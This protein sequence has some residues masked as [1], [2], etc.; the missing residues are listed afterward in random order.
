MGV[1]A[2]LV[3][4]GAATFCAVIILA[5][6]VGFGADSGDPPPGVTLPSLLVQ[7][8]CLAGAALLFA[9]AAGPVTVRQFGLRAPAGRWSW[10]GWAALAMLAFIVFAN[11]WLELIDQTDARDELPQE[12]GADT[13]AAAAVVT[14]AL[15]C[16]LAPLVE[17]F[18]FRGFIFPAMRNRLGLWGGAAVTGLLFG[19]AHVLGSPVAFLL[20]LA[21]LGFVLCLL[22]WRTGSLYPPI[23]LHAVN[24]SMALGSVMDWEW[25]T[26][27]VMLSSLA[28]IGLLATA[29]ARR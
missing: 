12:L 27:V 14:A 5:I 3:G 4:F 21:F 22:Y 20:P 17:E 18:L 2:L 13:S 6:G 9:R 8:I 24:N 26:P 28:L 19:G 15:V 25:Q 29:I 23:V 16:V 1:A 10:M 7:D 11:L